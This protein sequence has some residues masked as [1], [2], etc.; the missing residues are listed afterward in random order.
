MSNWLSLTKEEQISL[1]TRA[2]AE[3][4]LPPFAIE[5]DAWVSLILRMLFSS[6]LSEHIVFKGG[7]SLSK[8]YNLIERFSEDVDLAIN[9]EYLGFEGELNKGR[10]RKLRRASHSF[11]LHQLPELLKEQFRKYGVEE[12]LNKISIPNLKV[13]DQ[14]PETLFIDY[15]SV[16]DAISYLPDR[17]RIEVGARSLN[18]PYEEKS[19]GS[20][21]D[22]IFEGTDIA[23]EAFIV[24]AITPEKTF[25]EKMILLHEE[26]HK[27]ENKVRH[28]RMSRHLYDIMKIYQSEYG[29][30]ALR[31]STLFER[32]CEHRS[33]FT[34]V[35]NIDYEKLTISDL[36]F[37]PP[38]P[39]LQK[40]RDDYRVMQENMIYGESPDFDKLLEMIRKIQT[41]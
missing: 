8:V 1:F 26:F 31:D 3:T 30:K 21:I 41:S 11:T 20:M 27:D 13:S 39:H 37:I 14:D 25:L 36:S 6:T 15:N 38:E 24:K 10:I 9:R 19:I 16:F 12:N 23:E 22:T 29:H 40:Y 5:K 35:K 17:V 4:G 7:T 33:V 32:I 34:P 2:G 28:S 18:E